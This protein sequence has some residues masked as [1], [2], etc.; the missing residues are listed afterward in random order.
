ME[1][2][3]TMTSFLQTKIRRQLDRYIGQL[4]VPI[5]EKICRGIRQSS[6]WGSA[7]QVIW[8]R[9]SNDVIY[10][11][12]LVLGIIAHDGQAKDWHGILTE[13]NEARLSERVKARLLR[14]KRKAEEI[15]KRQLRGRGQYLLEA[16]FWLKS[17]DHS[18]RLSGLVRM[19]LSSILMQ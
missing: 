2:L 18:T 10:W 17:L 19:R 16:S 12:A 7:T 5:N 9:A 1:L 14:E 8:A 6:C 11:P 13:R 4:V 15:I 3:K